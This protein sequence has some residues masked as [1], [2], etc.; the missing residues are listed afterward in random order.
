MKILKIDNPLYLG[1]LAPLVK[2]FCDY[3]H[4]TS[5]YE[6]VSYESTWAYLVNVAQFGGEASELWGAFDD[7]MNPVGF[8]KWNVC[9]P[10]HFGKVYV[11]FL[12][13]SLK[14]KVV[15]VELIKEFKRFGEKHNAPLYSFDAVNPTVAKRLMAI[16]EEVGV[17]CHE[18]G[19]TN[20]IGRKPSQEK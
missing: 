15:S 2:G 7:E 12:Y 14:D 19:I 11:E 18:T 20:F 4:R 17:P 5:K 10:P 3:V 16:A 6:G 9:G 8:A 1:A 13:S